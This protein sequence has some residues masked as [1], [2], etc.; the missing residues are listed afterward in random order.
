M[1]KSIPK[2]IYKKCN[3]I[4]KQ[5]LGFS[6]IPPKNENERINTKRGYI[7]PKLLGK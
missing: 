7:F 2:K 3:N 4:E 5:L 6:S 1:P